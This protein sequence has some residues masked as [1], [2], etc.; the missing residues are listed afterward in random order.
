[1]PDSNSDVLSRQVAYSGERISVKSLEEGINK[2][3]NRQNVKVGELKQL[4][5][6]NIKL[7]ESLADEIKKLRKFSDYL[8]R[9]KLEGSF[10]ANIK[11]ILSYIPILKK[12]SFT[13][14]SVE[15]LLRQQYEISARRVKEA[16]EF[17]DKL[18]AAESDLQDEIA[19]LNERIIEAA[20]NEDAAAAYVL[21]LEQLN[22]ELTD[23]LEGMEESSTEKR[24]LQAQ[25]DQLRRL[26]GE[27]SGQ[28]QLYHTSEERLARLKE[29]SR[30]LAETI[31]NLASDITQYVTAAGEKL[32]LAAGQIQAIGTAADAS[33]VMLELKKS[34]DVMTDSMNQTTQFVSETQAFFRQNLDNLMQ[35]LELYDDE[36]Q[37]VMERNLKMS[38]E[39]EER[40]IA[41]AVQVALERSKESQPESGAPAP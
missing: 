36:T 15:E 2:V 20:R 22:K 18:K 41:E 5:E 25:H 33:V 30:M 6:R 34:L 39:V 35:E 27:H 24:E 37:K 7:Q 38:R 21:E 3:R 16:A 31:A 19:R 29:N 40:R 28:L 12:L 14:R 32:D 17:V 9:G 10:L 1:M 4:R 26:M 11:E 8:S 23:K 13:R